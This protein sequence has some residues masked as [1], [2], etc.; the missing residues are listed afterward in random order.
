[1]RTARSNEPLGVSG[2]PE[3]EILTFFPFPIA[4]DGRSCFNSILFLLSQAKSA[5][6]YADS[7]TSDRAE[8][9]S[10][11]LLIHTY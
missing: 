10:L 11:P 6:Y 1:M 4:I 3:Q 7:Y 8:V 2:A 5:F 9:A